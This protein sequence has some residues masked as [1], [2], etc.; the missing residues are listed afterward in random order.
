[1]GKSEARSIEGVLLV[2]L[3][4]LNQIFGGKPPKSVGNSKI[5]AFFNMTAKI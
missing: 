2:D 5:R 1:M 4:V 3:R